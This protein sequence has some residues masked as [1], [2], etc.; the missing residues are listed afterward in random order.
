[1]SNHHVRLIVHM[2]DHFF[3]EHNKTLMWAG[4]LADSE[5]PEFQGG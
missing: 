2:P 3:R 5:Y 1:L 4:S